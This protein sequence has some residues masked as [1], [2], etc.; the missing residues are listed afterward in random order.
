MPEQTLLLTPSE[1]AWDDWLDRAAHDF[2]HRAAYHA[3]SE[4]MGEGQA[5]N[6]A[7]VPWTTRKARP[8]PMRSEKAW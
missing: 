6:R 3:F 2:Y 8:S 4:R 1:P 7:G 5:M